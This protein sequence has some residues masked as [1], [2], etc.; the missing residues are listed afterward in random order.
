M[1]EREIDDVRRTV[2]LPETARL[3]I[4][5]DQ[6]F[7]LVGEGTRYMVSSNGVYHHEPAF[8]VARIEKIYLLLCLRISGQKFFSASGRSRLFTFTISGRLLPLAGMAGP[9][10]LMG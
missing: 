10:F 5:L 6:P 1:G 9:D 7:G 3:N 4:E 8:V 2:K